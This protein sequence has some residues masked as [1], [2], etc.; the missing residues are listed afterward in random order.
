VKAALC[1]GSNLTR[2]PRPGASPGLD[3]DPTRVL[4]GPAATSMS[5]APGP[6]IAPRAL[7]DIRVIDLS[8][9]VA[10]PLAAMLMADFGADVIKAEPPSGDPARSRPGFAMWNRNKRSI[11]IDTE[12]DAGRN[13]LRDLVGA[14]DIVVRGGGNGP[15]EAAID[16]DG[17]AAANPRLVFLDMPPFLGETPWAGAGESAALL[18]ARCGMAL[19]QSSFD[20]GPI[21][22]VFPYVLYLQGVWAATAAIAALIE[23]Q[24]SGHGQVVTVGGVHA[25]LVAGSGSMVIDPEVVE[26]PASFGPGGPNPMYTRY[27]CSDS[28]WIFLATLTPKFQERALVVLGLTALLTDERIGGRL[29]AML[30]PA[31]RVWVRQRF[32]ETFERMSSAEWLQLLREADVPVGPLLVR[33]VWMDSPLLEAIGMRVELD[34]PERGAVVMPGNPI[35]LVDT[36]ATVTRPAPRVG[37]DPAPTRWDPVSP[38]TNGAPVTGAPLQGVRV[39]DLGTILAGP[40]TG[41]LLAELGAD[42]IKI[43]IPAGDSWRE[44]GMPYIRG[45]RGVAMDLRSESGRE[46]FLTLVRAAD[47]VVDNYRAGVLERLGIDYRQLAQEKPDIVAVSITGFGEGGPFSSEPAFDPLLQARSGMMI[48]QGG[49]SEP[50]MMTVAINDVTTA[51]LATLGTVLALF[52]KARTGDGQKVWLSLAG[53]AAFAQCEEVLRVRNRPTP[54]IGGRDFRG[55][56]PLDRFYSTSDGWVR[57]QVPGGELHRLQDAVILDESGRATDDEL[58]ELISTRLAS[59]TSADAI[60]HLTL[61]GVAAAPARRLSEL[62]DDPEYQRWEIFNT[63]HREGASSLRVPGRYAHFSRSQHHETLTPPGVGEHTAEVLAEVGLSSDEIERLA[64]DGA[65]HLGTPMVF[66]TMAAYR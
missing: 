65:V 53:T 49:N 52:H 28:V 41:T 63:L 5:E 47:V 19:R 8:T 39:L 54:P 24:T 38:S 44:R 25:A 50:V 26:V 30:A 15:F 7:A 46:A 58:T 55:P 10:G 62:S 27:R 17:A 1:T 31:N 51:A 13:R 21:D 2:P 23:R 9:G 40:Y 35:N 16:G 56:G 61:A 11:V 36:P 18:W 45:Q 34:D 57:L 6:T 29:D 32:V 20:G 66:R 33:D 48:A 59:M 42:V 64:S 22:P 12:T 37:E 4:V 60:R 3:R 43:E 14:A